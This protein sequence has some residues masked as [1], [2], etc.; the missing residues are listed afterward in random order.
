MKILAPSITE[1]ELIAMPD[2][3]Q[4][5]GVLSPEPLRFAY[6][7]QTGTGM[8]SRLRVWNE[9]L[10]KTSNQAVEGELIAMDGDASVLAGA[11]G[12]EWDVLIYE[13][14]GWNAPGVKS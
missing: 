9:C 7:Y 4:Q 8:I 14:P 2:T 12:C 11:A 13:P 10:S 6:L 1:T 3:I 5:G